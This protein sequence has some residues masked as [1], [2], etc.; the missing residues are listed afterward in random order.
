MPRLLVLMLGL[1]VCPVAGFAYSPVPTP[2]TL[3]ESRT[4]AREEADLVAQQEMAKYAYWMLIATVASTA[5]GVGGVFGLIYT[6]VL[7]RRALKHAGDANRI[8]EEGL[9]NDIRPWIV[10]EEV[11]LVHMSFAVHPTHTKCWIN[12]K[13]TVRNVGKTPAAAVRRK[14]Y[15]STSKT[16]GEEEATGHLF[17]APGGSA[18]FSLAKVYDIP[19]GQTAQTQ[20]ELLTLDIQIFY[21][22]TKPDTH[23][24]HWYCYLN[25]DSSENL[26]VRGMVPATSGVSV[27][28]VRHLRMT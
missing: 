6:I 11:Q 15:L 2:G 21:K 5:V 4:E 12:G 8:A 19:V 18:Q 28:E 24:T 3:Q 17:I 10:V 7:T 26:R 1:L 22:S 27:D 25:G 13:Y 14:H 20:D 23:E 16:D 9:F